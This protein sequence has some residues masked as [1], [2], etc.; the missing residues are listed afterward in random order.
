M[1]I[2]EI[3]TK[4]DPVLR[5][6]CKPVKEMTERLKELIDDM[7]DTM[8]EAN[9]VGL[10]APQ[11]GILK[12]LCVIDCG[13]EEPE[14][15]VLIN[16]EVE[17]FGEETVDSEGCLSVPGYQGQVKRPGRVRV[18]YLNEDMEECELETDGLLARCI[19]HETDHL[20]GILYI[21]KL[22]SELVRTEAQ[23]ENADAED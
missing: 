18:R 19:Q 10:A 3:R 8:Y 1:A 15:L 23:D 21:D 4:E 14:P 12:Q 7:F 11:V 9:G 2:R 6:H 5:K 16:P 20:N 13:M 17:A 22:E